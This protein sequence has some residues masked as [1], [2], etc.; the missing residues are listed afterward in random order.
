MSP[1][2]IDIQLFRKK[3]LRILLGYGAARQNGPYIVKADAPEWDKI[4]TARVRKKTEDVLKVYRFSETDR[5]RM[6][7]I[8]KYFGDSGSNK[9]CEICDNCLTRHL[10]LVLQ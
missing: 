10:S 9:L 5:C 7:E 4:Y 6:N 3:T 2:F 1:K 8:S